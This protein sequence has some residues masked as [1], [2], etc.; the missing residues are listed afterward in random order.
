MCTWQ[1]TTRSYESNFTGKF[2]HVGT[3]DNAA[4]P[5]TKPLTGALFIR[6]RASLLGLGP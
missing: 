3:Y 6:F 5:L 1:A 2:E 4:D